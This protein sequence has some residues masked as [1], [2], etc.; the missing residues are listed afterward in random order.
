M[1]SPKYILSDALDAFERQ[2]YELVLKLAL[3]GA[4]ESRS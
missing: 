4:T 3:P 2:D 1:E